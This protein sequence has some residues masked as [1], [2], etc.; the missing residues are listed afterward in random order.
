MKT[1]LAALLLLPALA[2]ASSAGLKF[3]RAPVDP[4]DLPSLQ[5]GAQGFVNYCLNCHSAAYMRYNRLRDLGLSEQQ[6]KDNLMFA[7]DKVGETMTVAMRT[8]DAAQWFG[9]A[10][11]DLTV[12]ARSRGAD[13]LYTYLRSFYRD[14]ARPTGWNNVVFPSVGMPHVLYE[15]QG[16]QSL[17]VETSTDAAGHKQQ[18]QTLVLETPGTL[19]KAQYDQFVGDLVNY[20]D[21][22]GEPSSASRIQIGI[23]VMM[24]L[25]LFIAITYLL[26]RA[27][28]K[29]VH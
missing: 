20:L 5:R 1:F 8:K 24:F 3:D 23:Y 9:A 25:V 21:Y 12:I 22:M 13:W 4:T 19:S 29:D 18:T 17:K 26:K 10:P 2:C 28:W 27:Y 16:V 14:P 7:A 6:V 11:P 15:L